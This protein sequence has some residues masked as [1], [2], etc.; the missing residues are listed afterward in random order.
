MITDVD[1]WLMLF[2]LAC[3]IAFMWDAIENLPSVRA[4]PTARWIPISERLPKD[5]EAVLMSYVAHG[6]PNLYIELGVY[7]EKK[8]LRFIS[9]DRVEVFVV[10]AWMPLPEP[11]KER[12]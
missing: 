8:F 12:E 3:L 4:K 2:G 9:D 1:V 5:G 11:Y 7:T 10:K 6:Y